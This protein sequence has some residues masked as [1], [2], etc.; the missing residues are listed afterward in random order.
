MNRVNPKTLCGLACVFTVTGCAETALLGEDIRDAVFTDRSPSCVA[1]VGQ[2][3]AQVT[4][5]TEGTSFICSVQ[6]EDN[7]EQ[8]T[9]TSNSIPNHDFN[10]SGAFANRVAEVTESFT[11]DANPVSANTTTAL[12]LDYD[13]AIFLNGVKLDLLA[14]ACYGVGG[15]PLGEEQIGCFESGTP[16]RYDPMQPGNDFGTDSHNA[17]TQ[18]D[19]AYHYHGD[20]GALY[21]LSGATESGV[22][23]FAADGYPIYGPYIEDEGT[24]R[25]VQSGYTLKSGARE[26]QPGE[27]A[28]P[29]GDYDGTFRD[30]YAWDAGNGDLDACNGMERDGA[31]GYY[32][33]DRFPWVVGCFSGTPDASFRKQ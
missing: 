14:A 7:V 27:G 29:G 23:G 17:H 22:I 12:T 26:S 18:P 3:S 28:F 16:W 13:N 31:Y 32:V 19:G 11:L 10:D 6:V 24:M 15:G 9:L 5:L 20:P 8:C 4:D 2:Y 25:Q 21:D 33:T 30:D 1:Y